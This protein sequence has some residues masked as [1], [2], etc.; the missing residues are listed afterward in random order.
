MEKQLAVPPPVQEW[1][2]VPSGHHKRA[3]AK[4][5]QWAEGGDPVQVRD[6]V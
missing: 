6:W 2:F 3:K 4:Q 5:A 1:S